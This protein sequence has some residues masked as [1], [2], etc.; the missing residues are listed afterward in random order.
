MQPQWAPFHVVESAAP[1]AP[2]DVKTLEGRGDRMRAAAFA[3]LQAVVAFGW[4][5]E[6]FQDS[7][8]ELREAWR[9]LVAEEKQH[10]EAIM[11]RMQELGIDPAGRPVS[12]R[13][14]ESLKSCETA[15]K[16]ARYM[17]NS[18]ER[19]RQ[20]GIR[21][22]SEISGADPTTAGIFAKIVEDELD[23]MALVARFYPTGS[24]GK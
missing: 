21:F 13:I 1:P 24:Q 4:A 17:A 8:K 12:A 14:W 11:K 20:A 2:R 19:G 18:E 5:A 22:V 3:E 6:F 23:H 15:E 10:Y 9:T 7:P 16:F